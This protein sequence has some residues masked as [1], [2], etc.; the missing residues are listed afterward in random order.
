MKQNTEKTR[1][2]YILCDLCED[3]SN[4]KI[5]RT[6]DYLNLCFDC[7]NHN[8]ITTRGTEGVV[9]ESTVRFMIGN[10]I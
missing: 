10:V 4:T 7:C 9:R 6:E 5:S 1:K 2:F 8:S 3:S